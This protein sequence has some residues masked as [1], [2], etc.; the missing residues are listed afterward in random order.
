[1][2]GAAAATRNN[3]Q[4]LGVLLGKILRI[5]PAPTRRH[6]YQVPATNPFVGQQGRRAAIWLYGV[7]NPWRISFDRA[8]R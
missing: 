6:P 7:R 1:M 4:N 2:T 3:G 5:N 8:D